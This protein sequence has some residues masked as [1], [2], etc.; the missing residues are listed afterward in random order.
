MTRQQW[1]ENLESGQDYAVAS[2]IGFFVGV[3]VGLLA[4]A[5]MIAL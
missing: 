2:I 4:A 1:I 5:A 3:V